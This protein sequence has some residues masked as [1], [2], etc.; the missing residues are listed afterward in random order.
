MHNEQE[1]G[2]AAAAAQE[3]PTGQEATN[4]ST[5]PPP[6]APPEA[7]A[8]RNKREGRPTSAQHNDGAVTCSKRRRPDKDSGTGEAWRCETYMAKVCHGASCT[9]QRRVVRATDPEQVRGSTNPDGDRREQEAFTDAQVSMNLADSDVA[10][11]DCLSADVSSVDPDDMYKHAQ[12]SQSEGDA[13]KA[14]GSCKRS[15]E[16]EDTRRVGASPGRGCRQ[17]EEAGTNGADQDGPPSRAHLTPRRS[18]TWGADAPGD[19]MIAEQASASLARQWKLGQRASELAGV[20]RQIATVAPTGA[21]KRPASADQ[22]IS[23][24][25]RRIMA[26]QEGCRAASVGSNREGSGGMTVTRAAAIGE[27]AALDN[28]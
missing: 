28:G 23:A 20:C 18:E 24:M 6:P 10:G 21:S 13:V 2:A 7:G 17:E 22:R 26:K 27:A 12:N 1:G 11:G 15:T 5:V 19:T 25:K 8:T 9:N 3:L 14:S 16:A 4:A